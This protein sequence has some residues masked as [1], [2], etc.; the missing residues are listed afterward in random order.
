MAHDMNSKKITKIIQQWSKNCPTE[1][2]W[3][4]VKNLL[5]SLGFEHIG[6]KGDD[7]KF[8][9]VDLVDYPDAKPTGI[10]TIPARKGRKVIKCYLKK[11][12]I[13]Y[14]YLYE[15]GSINLQG[16][17]NEDDET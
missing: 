4:T 16:D 10:I 12:L 1:E 6:F 3:N 9:H 15:K 5:E 2:D 14:N 13:Y 7:A 8:H 17:S 11:I